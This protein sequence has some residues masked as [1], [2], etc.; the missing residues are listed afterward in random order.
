MS[1]PGADLIY[2]VGPQPRYFVES[3][4]RGLSVLA[5]FTPGRVELSLR[6]IAKAARVTNPSALRIAY[7]LAQLGYLTRNPISKGY[8]L[9]PNILSL[10]MASLSSMTLIDIADPFLQE[11]RDRTE[12]NVKCAVL[13]GTE[14][15]YIARYPSRVHPSNSIFVGTRLVAHNTSMGRAILAYLPP[16]E[17]GEII[18]RSRRER[19]T[20]KTITDVSAI[21]AELQRTRERGY[22]VNDQGVTLEHRSIAAPLI[23]ARGRPVSAINI[24]VSASRASL[25]EMEQR[26]GRE[27]LKTAHDISRLLPPQIEGMLETGELIGALAD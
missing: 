20:D 2:D 1:G 8:R 25:E 15:V 16:E 7:T 9:G 10:G 24:S 23:N 13:Y 12:E 26:L 17:A 19:L 3:L 6:E 14:M 22:A 21:M 18:K 27:L 5:A 11:L 4:A